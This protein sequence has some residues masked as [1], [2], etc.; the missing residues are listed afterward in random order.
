MSKKC[1][2]Y[3]SRYVRT[4]LLNFY[5]SGHVISVTMET[6]KYGNTDPSAINHYTTSTKA[7]GP[8]LLAVMQK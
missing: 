6:T 7:A 1:K 2:T 8:P 5:S 3:K 4:D